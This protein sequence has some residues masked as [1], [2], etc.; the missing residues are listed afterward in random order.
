MEAAQC[1]EWQSGL[2]T[3][4]GGSQKRN[5]WLKRGGILKLEE[6]TKVRLIH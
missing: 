4:K 6:K 1:P 3:G 5:K 2:I